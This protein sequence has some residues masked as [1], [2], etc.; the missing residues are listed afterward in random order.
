MVGTM[1]WEENYLLAQ[2]KRKRKTDEEK[3]DVTRLPSIDPHRPHVT[4]HLLF[5]LTIVVCVFV[6]AC[7][8]CA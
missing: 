3:N 2:K 8:C 5:S 7:C 4:T 6:L 1:R